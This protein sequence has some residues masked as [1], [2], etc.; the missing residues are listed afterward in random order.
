MRTLVSRA[1]RCRRTPGPQFHVEAAAVIQLTVP[2]PIYEAFCTASMRVLLILI[3]C[4]AVPVL[5]APVEGSL[6]IQ[7]NIGAA[8]C[9]ASPQPPLQVHAYEPQTFILRES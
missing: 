4:C 1:T 9:K 2:T 5:G 8:D 7:W 6:P 3:V